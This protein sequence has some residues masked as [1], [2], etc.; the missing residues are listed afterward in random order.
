MKI[1]YEKY[2]NYI[3]CAL[4]EMKMGG[5][6]S[7]SLL[8]N[9]LGHIPGRPPGG[10]HGMVFGQISSS[11]IGNTSNT[12]LVPGSTSFLKP[13]DNKL[14]FVLLFFFHFLRLF[15]SRYLTFN[16]DVVVSSL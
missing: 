8:P 12:P 5:L 15:F 14:D 9:F 6:C 3:D 11:T 13:I 10:R 1:C 4:T 2:K 16:L 7:F